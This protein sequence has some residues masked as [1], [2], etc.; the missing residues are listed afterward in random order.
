[1]LMNIDI[2]INQAK[3][4]RKRRRSRIKVGTRFPPFFRATLGKIFSGNIGKS[5]S[6]VY[7]CQAMIMFAPF[8]LFMF[9]QCT[10]CRTNDKVFY[11]ELI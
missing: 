8:S 11:S 6:H 3:R 7:F 1:M 4:Q 2:S 10:L 9:I 5:L